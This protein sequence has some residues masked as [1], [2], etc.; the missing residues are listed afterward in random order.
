MI[1]GFLYYEYLYYH[2]QKAISDIG[3][4]ILTPTSK[5]IAQRSHREIRET[6]KTL[7]RIEAHLFHMVSGRF[8]HYLK[9]VSFCFF[10]PD[11]FVGLFLKNERRFF[12][13]M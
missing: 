3:T 11:L 4:K 10:K 13:K 9:L 12:G 7:A 2:Y 5:L 6:I 8:E 1:F